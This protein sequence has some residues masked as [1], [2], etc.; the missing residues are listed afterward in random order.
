MPFSGFE[1]PRENWSKLPHALINALPIFET[2]GELCVVLYVLRHTWG[3]GEAY[4]R[5][6]LDEFEHG[7]RR[8]DGTRLDAGVGMGREA[9]IKGIRRAVK[10]G[11]LQVETDDR[12]GGRVRKVYSLRFNDLPELR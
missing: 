2:K 10:H 7:R 12:D 8:R 6:T 3:F 1:Y 11:F 9:I 5:I 4:R